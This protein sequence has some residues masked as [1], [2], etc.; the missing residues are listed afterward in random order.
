MYKGLRKRPPEA[1]T[2]PR[3]EMTTFEKAVIFAPR[4]AISEM[5]LEQF[6]Y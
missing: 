4:L 6:L 2:N 1:I 5:P 3:D